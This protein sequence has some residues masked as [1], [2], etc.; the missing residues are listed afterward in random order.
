MRLE[1]ASGTGQHAEHFARTW[2]DLIWQPSEPHAPSYALLAARVTALGLPNLRNP[3]P[4]D[5]HEERA[6]LERADRPRSAC[7][8]K[9]LIGLAIGTEDDGGVLVGIAERADRGQQRRLSSGSLEKGIAQGPDGA[10]R[11]EINDGAG[12]RQRIGLGAAR[13]RK[14][15]ARTV[16]RRTATPRATKLNVTPVRSHGTGSTSANAAVDAWRQPASARRFGLH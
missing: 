15:A 13:S 16:P 6:P 5:V 10:S 11:G 7:P 3:L 2:P 1:I 8:C 12:E 9:A 14:V 4:F